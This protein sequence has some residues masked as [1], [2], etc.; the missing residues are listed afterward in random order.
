MIISVCHMVMIVVDLLR[1]LF[2]L[3]VVLLLVVVWIAIAVGIG[4]WVRRD[5]E[6]RGDRYARRWAIIVFIF[7]LCGLFPGL[8]GVGWYLKNR[9]KR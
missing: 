6:G 9:K 1:E 7:T 3:L 4:S 8:L 2:A 5:A